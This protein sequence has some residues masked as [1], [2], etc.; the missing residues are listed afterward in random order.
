[1]VNQSQTDQLLTL[2]EA[3]QYLRVSVVFL[4]QKR[5]EGAIQSIKAGKKVL[6]RKSAIEAYLQAN[7]KE[8]AHA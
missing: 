7:T 6:I 4:W 8:V 2:N 3:A 5:K 1:M